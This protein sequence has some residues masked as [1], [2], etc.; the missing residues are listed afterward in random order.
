MTLETPKTLNLS[1]DQKEAVD[2]ILSAKVGVVT[3]PPGTGKSTCL[4]QALLRTRED[5]LLIAPTGKAA[6]RMQEVTGLPASTIHRALG[7]RHGNGEWGFEHDRRNPLPHQLVIVDEA[8][9]IDTYL[10]SALMS[11]IDTSRTRLIWVGDV[12]QLP[13]VGPGRVFGEII[14]SG[15]VPTVFLQN[16]HRAAASTWVFR[17]A[18][19]ILDGDWDHAEGDPTYKPVWVADENRGRDLLVDVVGRRMPKAG[20]TDVQVMSPMYAGALGVLSLNNALQHELN[21]PPEGDV[22]CIR[23]R[24]RGT[25]VVIRKD[26]QVIQQI[27]DY[28]RVVFNGEAGKVSSITD[29]EVIVDFGDRQVRYDMDA[30][31]DALRLSYALTIHKCQGS[32][33]RWVVVVCHSSHSTMWNRQLLYTAVTRARE[34]VVVLG[35]HRGLATALATNDPLHRICFLG[36]RLSEYEVQHV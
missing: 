8:S 14:E 23:F 25:D 9:M 4:G 13:S 27:N 33:W 2:L 20:I 12:D 18:P 31:R 36:T 24:E 3:G 21:P 5:V 17:V 35:D 26:D 32:E 30:A 28:D 29:Q 16:V 15:M 19:K 7:A 34:G 10:A 22:P 6:K 11:A 1:P